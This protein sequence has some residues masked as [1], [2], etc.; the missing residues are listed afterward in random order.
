MSALELS[1]GVRSYPECVDDLIAFRNRNRPT[2]RDRRYF[3]WRYQERPCA[4]PAVVLWAETGGRAVGALSVF[5]HDYYVVEGEYPLGVLGDIS[6]DPEFRG[7]G[8]AGAMFRFLAGVDLQ[9]RLGGGIVLPNE[10]AA[11]PLRKNGWIEANR[12]GRY[13]RILNVRP[14]LERR[15]GRG[16]LASGLSWP[17]NAAVG[18]APLEI[19]AGWRNEGGFRSAVTTTVDGRFDDLWRRCAK[20]GHVLGVRSAAYLRWRYER[21]P[22][23]R[24]E[25]FTLSR[26]DEL[27]GYVCYRMTD[28]MCIV[29][30]VFA[31]STGA[32]VRELLRTFLGHLRQQRTAHAVTVNVNQSY[33]E[34]PWRGFGFSRRADFQRVL[35]ANSGAI[36]GRRFT[37]VAAAAAWHVT[38]GDKDV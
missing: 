38:A 34:I 8:I 9:R 24:Y 21:H 26:A 10:E 30:D 33:L 16:T 14:Y 12:I 1:L 11:R 13:V 7:Q 25:I 31:A 37:D 15:L 27:C 17:L 4:I 35:V 29:D 2:V 20:R 28:G 36:A 23:N 5:P 32:S 3:D 22:V 18:R 19:L 6:V